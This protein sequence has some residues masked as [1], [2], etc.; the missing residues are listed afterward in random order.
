M[1][2]KQQIK[3]CQKIEEPVLVCYEVAS[4]TAEENSK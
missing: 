3:R 1:S 2:L 4:E